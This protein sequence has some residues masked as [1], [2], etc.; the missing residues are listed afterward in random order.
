MTMGFYKKL[1]LKKK[2]Y[3][4]S[5]AILIIFNVHTV[6]YSATKVTHTHAQILILKDYEF[7]INHKGEVTESNFP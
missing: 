4:S 6:K 2:K 7:H 3:G 5:M 1:A